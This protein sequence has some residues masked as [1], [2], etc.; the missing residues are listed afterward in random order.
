MCEHMTSDIKGHFSSTN[1]PKF[2][3]NNLKC[4]Y[5]IKAANSLY[6]QVRLVLRDID[7]QS[8]PAC[9][10]DYLYV[11]GERICGEDLPQR[12]FA[13]TFPEVG[14]FREVSFNFITDGFLSRRGFY[15][16]FIQ[17][18]CPSTSNHHGIS[19][20]V[21]SNQ[22]NPP[23]VQPIMSRQES[24]SYPSNNYIARAQIEQIIEARVKVVDS[25]DGLSF[26][27]VQVLGRGYSKDHPINSSYVSLK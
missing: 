4:L 2:Y 5:R 6:C 10:R 9:D 27:S 1:F 15:A 25:K 12:Q 20:S 17:E 11:K 3:N 16:E 7:I 21:T 26:P 13:L 18:F 22:D 23:S 14:P 24:H 8:S 19:Y